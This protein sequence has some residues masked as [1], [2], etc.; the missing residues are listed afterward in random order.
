MDKRLHNN[1]IISYIK[2]SC[3]IDFW[4]TA[5]IIFCYGFDA[6]YPGIFI[7]VTSYFIDTVISFGSDQI[8][9]GAV[10]KSI[11]ILI[12]VYGLRYVMKTVLDFIEIRYDEC[13]TRKI[14]SNILTKMGTLSYATLEKEKTQNLIKRVTP[15]A[16]KR[17]KEGFFN[18]LEI[19]NYGI[20]ILSI[21]LILMT[22]IPIIAIVTFMI[23]VPIMYV[24]LKCGEWDYTAGKEATESLRKADYHL[25]VINSKEQI[26]E[27]EIFQTTKFWDAKWVQNLEDAIKLLRKANIKAI[28][29]IKLS[30][31]LSTLLQGILMAFLLIAVRNSKIT[32]GLCISTLK[33]ENDLI[34]KIT[35]KLTDTLRKYQQLLM[36]YHDYIDFFDLPQEASE[37]N[38]KKIKQ[39]LVKEVS[40]DHVSFQ[41]PGTEKQILN[42]LSFVFE[43]G[44][45]Y[46]IVGMNGAG[47][48]TI[49]KLL[50][51][52][53]TNY[54]GTI[55]INKTSIREIPNDTLHRYFSILFQ[56][57]AR[58]E[59]SIEDNIC[60]GDIQNKKNIAEYLDH[61]GLSMKV[62]NMSLREKTF[63]GKLDENGIDLSGGEWQRIAVARCLYRNAPVY[64]MDEPTSAMDSIGE[65]AIADFLAQTNQDK[66]QIT[67]THRL[68]IAKK[69]N[70]IFVL[71]QGRIIEQGTH[72]ELM[73][74]HGTYFKMY[75][76]QRSWYRE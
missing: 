35:W 22:Q 41:Y 44:K 69:A 26:E 50:A 38:K 63:L 29:H 48:T 21:I 6:I 42:D 71:Q 34:T 32:I 45:H 66:I 1:S 15:E 68:G 55:S 27:R 2:N 19:I 54:T 62:N 24:S 8:T 13:C 12:I 70:C 46:S 58:Y 67:I 3:C 43:Q 73:K 36:Y 17:I 72:D 61:V 49:L 59:L 56:D 75:D 53:Y 18:S 52:L 51:G 31:V 23:S 65:Q 4:D 40:F 33:S 47:K 11:M 5:G 74:Y 14:N 30:S 20:Q 39:N 10:L 76:T 57:F 25:K 37:D 9:F 7:I 16:G 28:V 60:I 64:I